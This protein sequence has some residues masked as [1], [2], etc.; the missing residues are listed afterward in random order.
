MSFGSVEVN[1]VFIF[2]RFECPKAGIEVF[3]GEILVGNGSL[4]IPFVVF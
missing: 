1:K 3:H 2:M 4:L